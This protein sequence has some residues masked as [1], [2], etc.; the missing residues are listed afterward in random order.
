MSAVAR[1][2]T[3]DGEEPLAGIDLVSEH[4]SDAAPRNAPADRSVRPV[5]GRQV[6]AHPAGDPAD[7]RDPRQYAGVPVG[8]EFTA[9]ASPVGVKSGG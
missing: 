3:E 5:R 4:E 6:A 1:A 9:P 7:R 2:A 8:A